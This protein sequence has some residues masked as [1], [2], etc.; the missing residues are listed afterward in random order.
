MDKNNTT[1]E[2]H[3]TAVLSLSIP[4]V[5]DKDQALLLKHIFKIIKR[6]LHLGIE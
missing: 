3:N 2:L 1:K 4:K 5:N 6:S